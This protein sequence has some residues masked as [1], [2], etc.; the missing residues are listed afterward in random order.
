MHVSLKNWRAESAFRAVHLCWRLIFFRA[1]GIEAVVDQSNR[2]E[3]GLSGTKEKKRGV[4]YKKKEKESVL[5]QKT[6]KKESG[7]SGD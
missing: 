2:V 6:R 5:D 4:L 1:P 7:P 3:A